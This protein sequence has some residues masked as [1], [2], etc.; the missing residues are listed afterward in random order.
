MTNYLLTEIKSIETTTTGH[1]HKIIYTV[2]R[3][4]V[5]GIQVQALH[6]IR[7]VFWLLPK[8]HAF[9]TYIEYNTLLQ[10]FRSFD[11]VYSAADR[12]DQSGY[13]MYRSLADLLLKACEDLSHAAELN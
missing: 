10:I 6:D 13:K 8:L 3:P 9:T 7:V 1:A 2:D 4:L 5:T 12:F 11:S